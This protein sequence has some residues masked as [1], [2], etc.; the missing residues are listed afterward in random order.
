MLQALDGHLPLGHPRPLEP[1]AIVCR[2]L[3]ATGWPRKAKLWQH[4][5]GLAQ[6]LE[7]DK[8]QKP[9]QKGNAM[10]RKQIETMRQHIADV[11]AAHDIWVRYDDNV[12]AL[13]Y[14]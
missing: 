14:S 5:T 7:L 10:T 12:G 8:G 4:S 2:D 1:T 6:Q 11:C 13:R 3:F 9:W